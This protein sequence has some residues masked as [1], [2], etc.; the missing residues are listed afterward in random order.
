MRT[1]VVR[2]LK[3]VKDMY[4]VYNIVGE[5][6]IVIFLFGMVIVY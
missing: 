1:F 5:V 2:E 4:S 3:K 6:V